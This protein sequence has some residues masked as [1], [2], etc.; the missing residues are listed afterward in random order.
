V[1]ASG[2][3]VGVIADPS[4]A[5]IYA[6]ARGRGVRANG[7][8]VRATPRPSA[9]GLVCAELPPDRA[10]GFARQAAAEHVGVRVLGSPALAITQVALGHVVAAVL[11]G[12]REWDVAGA[13]CLAAEA[14]AHVVDGAGRPDPLPDGAM[15]VAVPGALEDVLR[16]WHAAG[17]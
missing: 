6:A 9:G 14:G 8:P 16:W 2:P 3:V 11:D 5:Q 7:V 15:V 13:I 10:P 17:P 4:R 1:D 12:Y